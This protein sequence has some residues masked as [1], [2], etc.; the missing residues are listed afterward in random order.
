MEA[1]NQI[2]TCVDAVVG[3]D[4]LKNVNGPALPKPAVD[5]LL[6]APQ[7]AFAATVDGFVRAAFFLSTSPHD[8]VDWVASDVAAADYAIAT[9]AIEALAGYDQKAPVE[10]LNR[11]LTLINSS[12][13]P[14]D[15]AALQG[16]NPDTKVIELDEVGHFPMLEAPEA[17]NRVLI[18]VLEGAASGSS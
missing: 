7:E 10:R 18:D 11:P 5:L 12:Y 8:V 6:S 3:V 13:T 16:A 2:G 4:T 17:F 1:A 14:T 9:R 15:V